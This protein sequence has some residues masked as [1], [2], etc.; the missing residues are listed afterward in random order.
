MKWFI[1]WALLRTP[2]M[3]GIYTSMDNCLKAKEIMLQQSNSFS[4]NSYACIPTS[5]S[6][7]PIHRR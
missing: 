5:Y 7:T 3:L 2:T 4:I 1:L 6:P